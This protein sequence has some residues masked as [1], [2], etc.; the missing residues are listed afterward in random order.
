LADRRKQAKLQWLHDPGEANEDNLSDVQ[1]ELVEISGIR[2]MN[3]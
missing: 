3:I 2:K 1:R